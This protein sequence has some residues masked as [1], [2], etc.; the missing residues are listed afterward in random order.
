[1]TLAAE[2]RR[3]LPGVPIVYVTGNPDL[4]EARGLGPDERLFA[5]PFDPNLLAAE[6]RALAH[7]PR[8][9]SPGV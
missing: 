6:V 1:L 8:G 9:P 7:A 3:R 2:V 5:K 4:V